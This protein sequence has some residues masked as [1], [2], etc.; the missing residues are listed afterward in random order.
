MTNIVAN[1]SLHQKIPVLF[2]S[3]EEDYIRVDMKELEYDEFTKHIKD[4]PNN[5]CIADKIILKESCVT[6]DELR[7]IRSPY[8]GDIL[9]NDS[10]YELYDAIDCLNQSKLFVKDKMPITINEII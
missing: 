1:L 6:T 10:Y 8:L 2:F 4:L 9:N 7:T 3:L 5:F